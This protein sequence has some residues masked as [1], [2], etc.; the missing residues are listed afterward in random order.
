[1]PL[2]GVAISDEIAA[3]FADRPYPGGLT[4]SGHPL[5]CAAAVAALTTMAEENIVERSAQLGRELLGPGLR[6][7]QAK[8]PSVGD[9]RGLGCFWALELVVDRETREPL[10]PYGTANAAMA[11]IGAAAR[12][13]GLLIFTSM[14]RIHLAPPLT[15]TAAEIAEGL[16]LLDGVLDRADRH[17]RPIPTARIA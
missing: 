4:Y 10:A 2:G 5:A 12:E 1:M 9:V 6:R 7:L 13:A 17:T 16:D 11:E 3:T 8:H 15:C 14:H